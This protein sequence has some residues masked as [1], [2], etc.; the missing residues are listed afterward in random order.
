MEKKTK[1]GRK[2]IINY[3]KKKTQQGLRRNICEERK[4]DTKSNENK[5]KQGVRRRL[6]EE[7]EEN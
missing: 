4:E 3:N 1:P 2:R 5:R 7:L 6:R